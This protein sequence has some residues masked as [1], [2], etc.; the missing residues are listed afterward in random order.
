M[1]SKKITRY[2]TLT[3]A[4][5]S[6]VCAI[7]MPAFAAGTTGAETDNRVLLTIPYEDREDILRVM[8]GNLDQV[9]QIVGALG[10]DD[11]A[12]IE[13]VANEMTFNKKMGDGLASRGNPTYAAMGVQFHAVNTVELRDAARAKDNKRVL[14]A[15]NT[16]LTTCTSCHA[17]F[18]VVEWPDNRSYKRPASVPLE[19]PPG[20][21][22]R[23]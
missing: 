21:K 10:E 16:T 2:L 15:L 3:G 9:K 8:R 12:T 22:V 11:F 20:A 6:I 1:E 4:A 17:T 5:I 23:D 13:K 7:Y 19:L 18:K 14:R